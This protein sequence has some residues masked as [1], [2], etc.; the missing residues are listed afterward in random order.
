[1]KK[2]N[3]FGIDFPNYLEITLKYLSEHM[4]DGLVEINDKDYIN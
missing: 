4:K 1:M 2:K 3:K